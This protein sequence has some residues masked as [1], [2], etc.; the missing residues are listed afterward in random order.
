MDY[1]DAFNHVKDKLSSSGCCCSSSFMTPQPL[2]HYLYPPP[3]YPYHPIV[4]APNPSTEPLTTDTPPTTE[5]P[6]TDAPLH[7]IL[8]ICI[9]L[10]TRTNILAVL[11][12]MDL[13]KVLLHMLLLM[14]FLLHSIPYGGTLTY[15]SHAP[16]HSPPG[17]VVPLGSHHCATSNRST[18]S[19]GS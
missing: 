12:L 6:S 13:M 7:N 2:F 5:A 3:P 14:V 19:C 9:L 10:H 18:C 11:L 15:G 16:F 4:D 17:T 1:L 8:I